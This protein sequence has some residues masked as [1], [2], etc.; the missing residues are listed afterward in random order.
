MP[1]RVLKLVLVVHHINVGVCGRLGCLGVG[2][3]V[4]AIELSGCN[5]VLIRPG[6]CHLSWGYA[7]TAQSEGAPDRDRTRLNLTIQTSGSVL[8]PAL[9]LLTSLPAPSARPLSPYMSEHSDS[10]SSPTLRRTLTTPNFGGLCEP[11]DSGA[12]S[13]SGLPRNQPKVAIVVLDGRAGVERGRAY[14]PRLA[15]LRL[16]TGLAD[17]LRERPPGTT[18]QRQRAGPADAQQ[19][20]QQRGVESR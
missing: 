4:P 3:E 15:A 17:S 5:A 6:Y 11:A 19:Q 16:G 13:S 2:W 12:R 8:Q 18:C 7:S 20:E 14:A 9:S 10:V 1:V